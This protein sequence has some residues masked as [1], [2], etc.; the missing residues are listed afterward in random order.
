MNFRSRPSARRGFT[1]IEL[2]VVIAIIAILIALLLPA[3]QQAREAARRTQCRNN[4]MNLGLALHNYQMAHNVFPPGSINPTGPISSTPVSVPIAAGEGEP[5]S[6]GSDPTGGAAEASDLSQRY[7][8]S[9]ATQILPYIEQQN[10]YRKID[11]KRSAYDPANAKVRAYSIPVLMCPSDNTTSSPG[12]AVTNYRG[13]NHDQ[14][15]PIDVDQNGLLFLNSAIRY[16]AIEDG[17]TNTLLLGEGVSK[18]N[19]SLGWMSGTRATLRNAS[20]PPNAS[21]IDPATGQPLPA[22]AGAN[23]A[24]DPAFV[25]SFSS[26]HAGGAQ[27]LMGDGSVKFISNNIAPEI[28]QHLGNR[29]DGELVGDF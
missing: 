24:A 4:L 29:R 9:W 10:A 5:A 3:V 20:A 28:F 17:S 14:E 21:A 23:D 27:F 6:V 18:V 8:M 15:T 26:P 12:V 11:F 25:G 22:L 1:L 2:L 19:A 7:E 13:C 16:E